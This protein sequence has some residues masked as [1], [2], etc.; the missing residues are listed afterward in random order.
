MKIN[1]R[2]TSSPDNNIIGNNLLHT[3]VMERTVY[4]AHYISDEQW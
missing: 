1:K 3:V 2:K 4:I